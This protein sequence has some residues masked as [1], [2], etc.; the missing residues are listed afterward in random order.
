MVFSN[1]T[2]LWAPGT[3]GPGTP[4]M[5][6]DPTYDVGGCALTDADVSWDRNMGEGRRAL[7]L[8]S[9]EA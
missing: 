7:G 9:L 5:D 8:G 6:T 3:L 2:G 4:D 1:R